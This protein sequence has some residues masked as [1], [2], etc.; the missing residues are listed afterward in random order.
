L[1]SIPVEIADL[2]QF[3]DPFRPVEF[4]MGLILSGVD[5]QLKFA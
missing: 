1:N 4:A 2:F 3:E 5:D